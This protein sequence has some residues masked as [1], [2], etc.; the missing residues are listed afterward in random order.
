MQKTNLSDYTIDD[1]IREV[2]RTLD[3]RKRKYPHAVAL[4]KI[5]GIDA[6]EYYYSMTKVLQ[7]LEAS[8]KRR[9]DQKRLF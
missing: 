7:I 5:K 3:E 9:G 4:K 6:K 8:K 1:A 2:K